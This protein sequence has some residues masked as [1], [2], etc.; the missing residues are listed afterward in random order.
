MHDHGIQQRHN[1]HLT[2]PGPCITGSQNAPS[3]DANIKVAKRKR[4]AAEV[5]TSQHPILN[6]DEEPRR[7]T[8]RGLLQDHAQAMVGYACERR[9]RGYLS[10]MSTTGLPKFQA[11]A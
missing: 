3:L 8:R 11:E 4:R 2:L 9:D 7:D 6:C 1:A 5:Q 10:A